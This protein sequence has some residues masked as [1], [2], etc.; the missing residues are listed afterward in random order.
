MYVCVYT[1]PEGSD[2]DDDGDDDD[3]EDEDEGED[4]EDDGSDRTAGRCGAWEVAA[5]AAA[6]RL[7]SIVGYHVCTQ[8]C[9]GLLVA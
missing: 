2:D 3:D 1:D 8:Y 7:L 9:R 5:A 4:E 6:A